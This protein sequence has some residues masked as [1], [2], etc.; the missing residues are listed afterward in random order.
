MVEVLWVLLCL[1]SEGLAMQFQ[2]QRHEG[3]SDPKEK[4]QVRGGFP[5]TSSMD[6][7]AETPQLQAMLFLKGRAGG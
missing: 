7:R 4:C 1:F 3:N 2:F 6:V 5:V